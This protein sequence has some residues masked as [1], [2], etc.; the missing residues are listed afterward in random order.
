MPSSLRFPPPLL[1]L[2]LSAASAPCAVPDSSEGPTY[3]NSVDFFAGAPLAGIWVAYYNRLVTKNDEIILG[4]YYANID[5]GMGTTNAPGFVVGY[6]RYLWKTLHIDY[7]LIP[8]WDRYHDDAEDKT[9]PLGL[10]LWNE[11]HL[12][13]DLD[14]H[15]GRLPILLRAQWPL[16][17]ALY[18]DPKGKSKAFKGQVD[19]IYW[20]PPLFFVGIRF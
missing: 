18:S 8:Q 14:F 4:P 15:P 3:R 16:G 9:Y 11:F 10:D 13:Y 7:Q 2:L 1:A 20:F 6:R 12:G 5:M 19:P 17:W